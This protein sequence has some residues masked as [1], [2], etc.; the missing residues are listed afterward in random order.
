MPGDILQQPIQ[1]PL[2]HNYYTG[3]DYLLFQDRISLNV[4][5]L[6][7]RTLAANLQKILKLSPTIV[8]VFSSYFDSPVCFCLV[9]IEQYLLV[10]G[11]AFRMSF[12]Q[13]R[14]IRG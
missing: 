5:A 1:K 14:K 2:S 6:T 10:V 4:S 3:E 12:I 9:V 7:S 13:A 11:N 8:K